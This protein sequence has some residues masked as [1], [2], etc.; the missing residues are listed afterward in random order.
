MRSRVEDGEE[1][2]RRWPKGV[3]HLEST[4]SSLGQ[5]GY[6][7]QVQDIT[8]EIES[9]AAL[10]ER[11]V[12]FRSVFQAIP[13]PTVVWRHV[14]GGN[15]VLH[16]FN[17]SANAA[18]EGRL[19]EYEGSSLDAFYAHQPGFAE[20][21]RQSFQTGEALTSE[22]PYVFRTTGKR[23]FIRIT[24]AKVGHE[25]VIDSMTDL[26]EL[27]EAQEALVENEARF[28][29]LLDNA[30]DI[31]Y[32]VALKPEIQYEYMS[33][34]AEAI[35][36]FTPAELMAD[37]DFAGSRDLPRRPPR[38]ARNP[39]RH[40]GRR[41]AAAA[42]LDPEGRPGHLARTPLCRQYMRRAGRSRWKD[43]AGG[44]DRGR[45]APGAGTLAERKAAAAAGSPSPGQEQPQYPGQPASSCRP[46]R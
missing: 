16:F 20:R 11:E 31:V 41:R 44:H 39:G 17:T 34:A 32:R 18:T 33:P 29:R 7:V 3:A 4:V 2:E 23:R 26:T 8:R 35:T 28:R 37:L 19:S 46:R 36:G 25:Y 15:F 22:Q 6:L 27:K 38:G 42:A 9:K 21:V 24:S 45:G 12:F 5:Q 43:R 40:P 14:G 10:R 30:P 13:S 1:K